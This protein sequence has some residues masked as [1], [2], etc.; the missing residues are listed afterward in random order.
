MNS[1]EQESV[2]AA[3]T[4]GTVTADM[5][6]A[7][8]RV[9]RPGAHAL[10]VCLPGPEQAVALEDAG[11]EIRDLIA[12]FGPSGV[13][14]WVLARK[15]LGGTVAENVLAHGTGALNI[16]ATRIGSG[17]GVPLFGS[18]T[19][20]RWG[21]G[22][23][24]SGISVAR[25][26]EYSDRG[27]WPANVVFM[28]TSDCRR[29]GTA[30]VRN[31]GGMSSGASALGQ[32]SGWNAHNNR[33]T[34][35]TRNR[36]ADGMEEVE[37]WICA[38]GCPVAALDAQ[39]AE[40]HAAVSVSRP[41]EYDATSYKVGCMERRPSFVDS[42]GASRF[43]ATPPE[44]LSLLR[45][46]VRLIA[47]PDGIVIDPS[48][49]SPLTGRAAVFEGFRFIGYGENGR[50]LPDPIVEV[51]SE[52]VVAREPAQADRAKTRSPAQLGLFGSATEAT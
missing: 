21:N 40:L 12:A 17:A 48:A 28:H 39:T 38:P 43:F 6:A 3:L 24:P 34:E 1:L 9:L 7:L 22:G 4:E 44:R 23:T 13:E 11:F 33:A 50:R 46:L 14:D 51:E 35:I 18:S 47:P 8:L 16:N 52:P 45:W 27:R 49:I 36:D 2:H 25:T 19:S 31:V 41:A 37:S 15:P 42:G 29:A 10:V 5:A 32:G 20:V 26:G 30:R